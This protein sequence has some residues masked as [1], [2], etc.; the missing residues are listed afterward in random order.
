V[1][2]FLPHTHKKIFPWYHVFRTAS[3]KALIGN[4]ML[5]VFY[6]GSRIMKCRITPFQAAFASG[7]AEAKEVSCV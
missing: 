6:F 4:D 1:S 7:T 2:A 3:E 5:V